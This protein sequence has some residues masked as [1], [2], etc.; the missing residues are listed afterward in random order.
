[1]SQRHS[2][3]RFAPLL[4]RRMSFLP[5][6]ATDNDD[7]L[8]RAINDES[9]DAKWKLHE[10]VD[11]KEIEKFWD[12]AREELQKECALAVSE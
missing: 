1:M 3:L 12:S 9:N 7:E 2:I 10:Q 5:V 8:I 4:R 11:P 6:A